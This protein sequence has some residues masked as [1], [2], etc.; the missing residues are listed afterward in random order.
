LAI[1]LSSPSLSGADKH[2]RVRDRVHWRPHEQPFSGLHAAAIAARGPADRAAAEGPLSHHPTWFFRAISNV[3]GLH[4]INNSLSGGGW[5]A[6]ISALSAMRL[7]ALSLTD[8]I[9]DTNGWLQVSGEEYTTLAKALAAQAELRQ[10]RLNGVLTSCSRSD[11]TLQAL[12]E[13]KRLENV[14]LTGSDFRK[15]VK[16]ACDALSW[17]VNAIVN[18]NV[19]VRLPHPPIVWYPDQ[20]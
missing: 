18:T 15:G 7:T 10:V 2:L 6:L 8:I 11:L 5:R 16:S 13:C 3:Q 19:Q 4:L 9:I 20:V 17:I 1:G 12:S 14:D